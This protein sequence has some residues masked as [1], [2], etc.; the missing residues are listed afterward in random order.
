MAS[1][2]VACLVLCTCFLQEQSRQGSDFQSRTI[3]LQWG[4]A[5]GLV[6]Y[7]GRGLKRKHVCCS[8]CVLKVAWSQCLA[9]GYA[10]PCCRTFK[11]Q[12]LQP[13]TPSDQMLTVAFGFDETQQRVTRSARQAK[14][15][16]DGEA[17]QPQPGSTR[18]ACPAQSVVY[19][20][21]RA[22]EICGLE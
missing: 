11:Q 20:R 2:S 9:L 6:K 3:G 7:R 22:A 14:A 19:G 12:A 13:Q 4:V 1:S 18:Q 21:F 10:L 17:G 15:D 8:P 5:Q 16:T